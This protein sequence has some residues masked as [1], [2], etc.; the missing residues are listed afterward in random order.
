MD[1]RRVDAWDAEGVSR[2]VLYIEMHDIPCPL[3]RE[4]HFWGRVPEV[5]LGARANPLMI[6]NTF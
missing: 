3:K 4:P 1:E 5:Y 6:T 2:T